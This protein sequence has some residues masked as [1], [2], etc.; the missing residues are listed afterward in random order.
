MCVNPE[1]IQFKAT[2]NINIKQ[3]Q[4]LYCS[5]DWKEKDVST[6][7]DYL[8]RS[9]A[10]ISVWKDDFLIGIARATIS[11]SKEVTIWDVAVRPEYQKKGIGSKIM[12]CMLTILDDYAIPVV[13]LYADIGKEGFY[14]KFGFVAHKTRT[15]AMIRS[16]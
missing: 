16:K 11:S 13:T 3:I 5:I 6:M 8:D 4:D 12:K 15:L 7:K 2:K 9:I 10:V 1:N 14:E